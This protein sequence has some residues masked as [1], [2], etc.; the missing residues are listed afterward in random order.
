MNGSRNGNE[1][2]FLS[3]FFIL[4]NLVFLIQKISDLILKDMYRK[5]ILCKHWGDILK[6]QVHKL[7][8]I[9]YLLNSMCIILC[10]K[11]YVSNL[12]ILYTT[13]F[14]RN[15]LQNLNFGLS[16]NALQLATFSNLKISKNCYIVLE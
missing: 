9:A 13:I 14:E 6:F 4:N 2:Q 3:F 7:I 5:V 1:L 10:I 16:T 8:W 15:Y 11:L 12:L